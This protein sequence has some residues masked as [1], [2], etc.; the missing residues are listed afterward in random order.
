MTVLSLASRVTALRTS[1]LDREGRG[2]M[3]LQTGTY[4]VLQNRQPIPPYP[5]NEM[6]LNTLLHRAGRL[7]AWFPTSESYSSIH[8]KRV[9]SSSGYVAR[10]L[11]SIRSE[12]HGNPVG[13]LTRLMNLNWSKPDTVGYLNRPRPSARTRVRPSVGWSK[14]SNGNETHSVGSDREPS[15]DGPTT[16]SLQCVGSGRGSVLDVR[17]RFTRAHPG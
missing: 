13:R 14:I 9:V 8:D 11:T 15:T 6:L 7:L 5:T 10:I 2:R 17:Y 12:P 3:L 4:L 16:E 1:A